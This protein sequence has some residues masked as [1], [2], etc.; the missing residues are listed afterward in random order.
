MSDVALATARD[1]REHDDDLPLLERALAERGLSSEVVVWDDGSVAWDS[2]RLVVVRSTWDYA[3]RRDEFLAWADAVAAVTTLRNPPDVLRW[4]T[5]KRYL[6][7][8]E[9]AGIPVVPTTWPEPGDDIRLATDGEIVVKP[10]VSAGARDSGRY[11]GADGGSAAAN[12]TDLLAAGRP[13]MAEPYL[14]AADRDGET[15]G[16][17]IGNEFSHAVRKSAIL[18]AELR[19]VAG[20]YAEERITPRTPSDAELSLAERVLNAV[21]GGRQ[22]LLYARVDLVPGADGEP[23]VLELEVAEPSLFVDRAAGSAA[24]FAGSVAGLLG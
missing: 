19:L 16:R 11:G 23:V 3:L 5:D 10:V 12:A 15:G 21:P 20:L 22:R 14:A 9:R 17:F 18:R 1:A 13:V 6:R 2:Y 4:N 24:R 8:L 7:E